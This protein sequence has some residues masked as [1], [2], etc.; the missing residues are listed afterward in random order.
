MT[1]TQNINNIKAIDD[2]KINSIY[3]NDVIPKILNVPNKVV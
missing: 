3:T 2:L 1:N